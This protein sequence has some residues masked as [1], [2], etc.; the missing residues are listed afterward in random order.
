MAKGAMRSFMDALRFGNNLTAGKYKTFQNLC[1]LSL[2]VVLNA[3]RRSARSRAADRIVVRAEAGAA[4]TRFC[5]PSMSEGE[6]TAPA[7]RI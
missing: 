5:E 2:F 3:K 1:P 6:S 4:L 7:W